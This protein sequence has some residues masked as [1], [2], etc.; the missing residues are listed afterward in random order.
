MSRFSEECII[1]KSNKKV[2]EDLM[3]R[4]LI[5]RDEDM[6]H[7][8]P[9]CWRCHTRLYYAPINAWYVDIQKLKSKLIESNKN[10]NWYPKHFKNGRF[11]KSLESAPDWNISRNRY[12]GSPVPVWEC[13]CG[14]RFVPESIKELEEVSEQKINN[15]HKP[16]ID[17]VKIKC[18]KCGKEVKRV[19]EVLDSWIEAGS[20]SFGERHYPFNDSEK[21][22]DFYPPDFIAEYTGQIR[23][24]FY[25]LH[26]IANALD[27]RTDG[28]NYLSKNV[29]VEGVILGTDGR[30]MSKNYNNYPDP[31]ELIGKYGGDAL[32][33]YLLGSP[34]MHGEDIIISE[35]QYRQQVKGMILIL[36]NS[37][38]FFI[39]Y[40]LVDK[41]DVK[42]KKLNLENVLDK[43][44][45][46]L[47]HRLIKDVTYD[48]DNFDT[49]NAISKINKFIDEFSTW[50]V[51]RSR[52]RV[53]PSVEDEDDK[54]AFYSTSH[55]VLIT[56]CK[57]L[58]PIAPFTVEEMYRNLTGEESVHL[59][60]WPEFNNELVKDELEKEMV[61]ARQIVEKGHSIRKEKGIPVKQALNSSDAMSPIKI[62]EKIKKV[63][64]EELNILDINISVKDNITASEV[65]NV[66]FNITKK[67][68]EQKQARDLVRKI[69]QERKK[70]GTT[71]DEKVDVALPSWPDKYEDEIKRKALIRNLTKG[72][73]SVSKI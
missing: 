71:L 55:E 62:D 32:R 28:K 26:V 43:W 8:V 7:S 63:I 14:E 48:L 34:V 73:F 54:N 20:A 41:W 11:L 52:E 30:K 23:A 61:F 57:L 42:N 9:L 46:S 44:I 12:W 64:E 66:D 29:L 31:K 69:Q 17:E 56:V 59:V 21:L 37:Y 3:N 72:E 50:Y 27:L 53:G 47:L 24:W 38:N 35:E 5:Y 67:L 6:M 39:S 58:A 13:T 36:W 51:R 68:E 25:V 33:L 4:N 16:E 45:L 19:N 60:D 1:L 10:V 15:L 40:A 70:L 22:E 2:N 49:A 18:K 65:V